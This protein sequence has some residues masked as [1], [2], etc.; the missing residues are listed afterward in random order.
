MSAVG[1]SVY[2]VF[3]YCIAFIILLAVEFKYYKSYKLIRTISTPLFFISMVI[4]FLLLVSCI[5]IS[6]WTTNMLTNDEND[7]IPNWVKI[8]YFIVFGVLVLLLGFIN[9]YMDNYYPIKSN[10]FITFLFI[11]YIVYLSALL[12]VLN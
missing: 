7:S 6:S 4:S 1:T 8:Y 12:S 10:V 2:S 9:G 3:A 11:L 5:A